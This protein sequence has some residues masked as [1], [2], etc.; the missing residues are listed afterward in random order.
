MGIPATLPSTMAY[1]QDTGPYLWATTIH[2]RCGPVSLQIRAAGLEQRQ[3]TRA[4][5]GQHKPGAAGFLATQ[6]SPCC[7][8]IHDQDSL[9]HDWELDRLRGNS[10]DCSHDEWCSTLTRT[11]P[12]IKIFHSLLYIGSPHKISTPWGPAIDEA[13]L[14]LLSVPRCYS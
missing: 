14:G 4:L 2:F 11:R 9:G 8:Y 1:S 10:R 7:R 6:E 5:D 3:S 12:V 13:F